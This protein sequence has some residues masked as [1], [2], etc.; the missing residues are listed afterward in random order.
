LY[1][2]NKIQPVMVWLVVRRMAF[3]TETA[4]VLQAVNVNW[5]GDGWNV[6]SYLVENPNEWNEGNQVF[7]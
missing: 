2:Q 1:V 7:S 3:Y 4:G 5:N 6:N